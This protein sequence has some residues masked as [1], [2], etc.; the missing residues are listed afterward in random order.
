MVNDFVVQVLAA[1]AVSVLTST[2]VVLRRRAKGLP[3][4]SPALTAGLTV[5][6]IGL[7]VVVA[8]LVGVLF[9]APQGG[10]GSGSPKPVVV[11]IEGPGIERRRGFLTAQ[12]FLIAPA[13]GMP[14]GQEASVSWPNGGGTATAPAEVLRVGGC[15][16]AVAVLELENPPASAHA[17]A[18]AG[19]LQPGDAVSRLVPKEPEAGTVVGL[20]VTGGGG[21]TWLV[22]T[23][24]NNS[25]S[26]HP[27]DAGAPVLDANGRM[28]AMIAMND[29]GQGHTLSLP[30]EHIREVFPWAFEAPSRLAAPG[31]RRHVVA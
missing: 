10:V 18:D 1:A 4:P 20:R 22:T 11:R 28:V 29:P 8:Y 27:G 21:C 16:R 3:R 2:W 23:R 17:F 5:M 31:A 7:A 6:I 30:I 15:E 24:L 12:G 14:V 9:V 13:Y 26:T 25:S 19:G